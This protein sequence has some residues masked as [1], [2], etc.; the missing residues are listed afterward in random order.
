[1]KIC[2]D[3]SIQ[4]ITHDLY[5]RYNG[6]PKIGIEGYIQLVKNKELICNCI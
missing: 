5:K 6:N 4:N 2:Y 1:M 3:M